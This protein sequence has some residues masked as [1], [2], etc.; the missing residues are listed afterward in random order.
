ML[1]S[2]KSLYAIRALLELMVNF[3]QKPVNSTEI[4]KRQGVSGRFIEIILND[5]KHAGIVESRRGSNGGYL[6]AKEPSL[7]SVLDI[8][9]C[10]D[11]PLAIMNETK[12]DRQA[13][14]FGITALNNLWA[15]ISENLALVLE[16]KTLRDLFKEEKRVRNKGVC[17]YI[18]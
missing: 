5:L 10:I 4:A 8:I 11:G 18:I 13:T 17:N 14:Y 3:D 12:E 1:V 16:A 7:I 9:V 15:E 6:L 2:K